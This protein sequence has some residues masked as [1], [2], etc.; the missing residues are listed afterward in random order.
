MTTE[1]LC[2]LMNA[3]AESAAAAA[4]EPFSHI[5][6][7]AAMTW[8]YCDHHAVVGRQLADSVEPPPGPAGDLPAWD[9]RTGDRVAYSVFEVH[10]I[11]YGPPAPDPNSPGLCGLYG[12]CGDPAGSDSIAGHYALVQDERARLQAELLERW[13]ACLLTTVD[14]YSKSWPSWIEQISTQ[15]AGRFT[16]TEFIVHA[17]LR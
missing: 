7:S 15:S 5:Y 8:P 1:A 4:A 3:V 6:P 14:N 11:R 9:A 12:A 17:L 13:C 10:V 2:C 16:S